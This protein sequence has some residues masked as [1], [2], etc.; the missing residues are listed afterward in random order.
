GIE[1]L[2]DLFLNHRENPPDLIILDHNMPGKNG[3]ELL[4]DLQELNYVNNIKVL[5]ITGFAHLQHPALEMGVSKF[6]QKPFDYE[7]LSQSIK[8]LA[9]E[10]TTIRM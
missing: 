7:V 5:F 6:V 1:A 2:V 9:F 4:Q 8:E 10:E 3:L